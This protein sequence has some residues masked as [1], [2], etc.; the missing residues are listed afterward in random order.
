MVFYVLMLHENTDMLPSGYSYDLS[1]GNIDT[2]ERIML[3]LV[4]ITVMNQLGRVEVA[5]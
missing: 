4:A 5:K 1:P 3:V 2:T